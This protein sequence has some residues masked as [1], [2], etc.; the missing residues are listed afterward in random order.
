MIDRIG[1]GEGVDVYFGFGQCLTH[2]RERSGSIAEKDRQLRGCFDGELGV[3]RSSTLTPVIAS[4]NS[5][6][7]N[8]SSARTFQKVNANKPALIRVH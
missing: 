5:T 7:L 1:S 4:D 2:A 6:K 3:H 8:G